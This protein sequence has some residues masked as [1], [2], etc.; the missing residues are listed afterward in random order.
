MKHLRIL[1]ITVL[2]GALT[3][4]TGYA[5]D[6]G[7][8]ELID[9]VQYLH[10]DPGLGQDAG[11]ARAS[12]QAGTTFLGTWTFDSGPTCTD[13]GWVSE[14]ITAPIG[15][16]W[17]VD[18][19]AAL[20]GGSFGLLNPLQGNQSMWCGARPDAGSEILCGYVTLPGYGNGWTQMVCSD[21]LTVTGNV[22]FAYLTAWDSEPGWDRSV[23][24]YS[25][26]D[27]TW[28]SVSSAVN[29][30][31]AGVYD[32]RQ[33]MVL[34]SVV[35]A[36][37][38]HSGSIRFR[39]RFD[40]D[41]A[42][43]DE[44]GLWNT[45]GAII[46][47]SLV[48]NDGTGQ[49][50]YEDFE[51]ASVGDNGAG[52]WN[53]CNMPGYGDY[54][55]LYP[56]LSLLQ[57]DPCRSDLD[58]M[59]TFFTGSTY[60]YACAGHPGVTVVP[61]GN[62][63]GQYLLNEVWSPWLPFTGTGSQVQLHFYVY[64]DLGVTVADDALIR[65]IY[66]VRSMV[67]GCPLPWQDDGY[68]YGA[69]PNPDWLD[70]Q[71]DLGDKIV[72]GATHIQV[73]LGVFDVCPYVC[74]YWG[75]GECHAPGPYFDEVEVYRIATAGPQ[76]RVR[77]ID[78]FQD[79]FSTDGTTTGTV[80]LDMAQD[81]L[82][83]ANP[84]ILPGDSVVVEASDPDVGLGSDAY[85]GFG[86]AVYAFVRVDP[87]Q[88]GKGGQDLVTDAFRWPLV[89]SVTTADGNLWYMVRFDTV[90]TQTGRTNPVPDRYCLDLNDN[91]LVPGDQLHYFFGAHSGGAGAW[92][93]YFNQYNHLDN[94]DAVNAIRYGTDID[95]AAANAEEMTCLPDVGG[96]PGADILW[97][98]DAA[99]RSLKPF[100]VTALEQLN[101]LDKVDRYDV[102]G[103][104]SHV[105]NGLQSRVVD[106]YQQ[107]IPVY[108]KIIWT[109]G[110]LDQA[111]IGDG[112][113]SNEKTDDYALLYTF[114][115]QSNRDPGVWINGDQIA[116]EWAALGTASPTQL[117]TAYMNFNVVTADH[118]TVGLGIAPL[119]IG[120][121]GGI[122]TSVA[123][124][125]TMVAFGGC[126]GINTFDVMQPTGASVAEA[127]YDGNTSY[128]SV[129]S[130]TTYPNAAGSTAKVLLSG[131][132][133][134]Y[135]RD[136][137][138]APV[139]DRVIHFQ[140]ALNFL[141]N[142]TDDPVAV[143]PAVYHNS[144]AQNRP[145]PFN[146][147]TTIEFTVKDR[148]DVQL[149]IY[150]VAGQLVRTLVDEVKSPGEVH[151]ATWDGRNDA[152]QS[153]SSGVY[154]YK[155]VAGNFVQTKKMVL[156]K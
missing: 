118:Q 45:D 136:D 156:L 27:D 59:W 40:S 69:F 52:D 124:P 123:G 95:V 105:G 150:N 146:P 14:D 46:V 133:I 125:D 112:Q 144:L 92:T 73:A 151:T 155:L 9:H 132:S 5:K 3:F 140:R 50:S 56:G 22:S 31:N 107:L 55:A 91:L 120:A 48:V 97:V 44:D 60:D 152:G 62:A 104:T 148:T 1:L 142:T 75:S 83:Q 134:H 29:A 93:Y 33:P 79:N 147:T 154:F 28:V 70:E 25:L 58:C 111:A 66:H 143:D 85:T 102:I 8:T 43:S 41:T 99:Y 34:D 149:R 10:V 127:Y 23:I 57:E 139:M 89:D 109:S 71:F 106:I 128:A 47:D 68:V 74:G 19:F 145:N 135:I 115:D 16:F 78:I 108:K 103:P 49:V 130:Q 36:S 153:V 122:F 53:S 98:N 100:V 35:V 101:L 119:S 42:W 88:P 121:G 67:G 7:K 17:H 63:R 32:G 20:G 81:I 13:E 24:Q 77:G 12:M 113:L 116:S 26:C 129:L 80:R 131:Y 138:P 2:C 38:D 90:F 117:R 4:A 21:C 126:A 6:V 114:L 54:A 110:N 30:G 141:G 15:T 51:G 96:Q 76:W 39:F 72:P 37:G 87:P 64:R 18:D 84:N 82:V 94:A 11:P 137:R 65:Y 86:P 61:Y